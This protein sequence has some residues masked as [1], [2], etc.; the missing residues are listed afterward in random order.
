MYLDRTNLTEWSQLMM[1]AWRLLG[2]KRSHLAITCFI[3]IS[4]PNT[5]YV[6]GTLELSGLLITLRLP[7]FR[8]SPT[9]LFGDCFISCLNEPH[10]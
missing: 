5:E 1:R 8:I 9:M 6:A 10:T 3:I 2:R 7:Y 4:T